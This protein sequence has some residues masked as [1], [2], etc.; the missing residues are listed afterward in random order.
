M[1]KQPK[2][3]Y[4][5]VDHQPDDEEHAVD[6]LVRR[7]PRVRAVSERV[8]RAMREFDK[9]LGPRQRKRW[10]GLEE[11]LAERAASREELYFDQ[12]HAHGFAAGRAEGLKSTL[13]AHA[14]ATVLRDEALQH[15]CPRENA[16][17]AL[18][19]AAWALVTKG[20]PTMA[21]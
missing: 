9:A 18:L 12:G 10:L 8:R 13:K 5:L 16:L 6:V 17:A 7:D 14:L 15:G 20:K 21:R 11:L 4:D 2:R 1:P 3:A 19:E